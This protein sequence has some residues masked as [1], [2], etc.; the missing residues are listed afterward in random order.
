MTLRLALLI[1]VTPLAAV[2]AGSAPTT[3]TQTTEQCTGTQVYDA[4]RKACIDSRDS[5]LDDAT[6]IEGARELAT[7]GRADDA[8]RVLATLSDGG[9][10]DALTVR[11]YATRKAGDFAGGVALY[12][13]ALALDP[14]NWLARSYLGQGLLEAGDRAGAEAQLQLIRAGG[15]RGTW[16]ETA[17]VDAFGGRSSY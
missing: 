15:A 2:A 10:S 4:A 3:P 5:R 7:Y 8:L 9:T 17:L 14:E 6:R 12:E 16:P 13:A 11:G 1:A